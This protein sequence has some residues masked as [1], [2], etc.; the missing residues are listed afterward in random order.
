M[1]YVA[2][3]LIRHINGLATANNE[4]E[5]RVSERTAQLQEANTFIE[6]RAAERAQQVAAVVHDL[7]H[8]GVAADAILSLLELDIEDAEAAV[9]DVK[10]RLSATLKQVSLDEQGAVIFKA[11]TAPLTIDHQ[12]RTIAASEENIVATFETVFNATAA[13]TLM[14]VTTSTDG[15]I[16]QRPMP[17]ITLV[18]AMPVYTDVAAPIYT[19]APIIPSTTIAIGESSEHTETLAAIFQASGATIRLLD[20]IQILIAKVAGADTDIRTSMESQRGLLSDMLDMAELEAAGIKLHPAVVDFGTIAEKVIRL[21]A[22]QAANQHCELRLTADR[23]LETLC[24]AARLER[25]LH[26]VIGNAI[27]Y[28]GAFRTDGDGQIHIKVAREREHVICRVS[29][30]GPGIAIDELAWL[31]QRF[32]RAERTT[33]GASGTGLGLHFCK[34]VL[35]ASGGELR[36]ESDGIGLGSCI[37]VIVPM[38]PVCTNNN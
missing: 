22:P 6:Q 10:A 37:S 18:E 34:G 2:A 11:K 26:N 25:V 13:Q 19:P 35:E 20:T 32:R 24:D 29:D 38:L 15:A 28:T 17:A 7:R 12:K 36:I 21:L 5:Q 1:M 3:I 14:L 31:G 30:N 23:P 9:N 27:K 8:T 33:A 4:L 16:I